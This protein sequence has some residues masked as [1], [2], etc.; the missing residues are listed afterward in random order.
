MKYS[1]GLN[2]DFDLEYAKD[3]FDQRYKHMFEKPDPYHSYHFTAVS[4]EEDVGMGKISEQIGVPLHVQRYFRTK[5]N[6]AG[7]IHIDCRH[8]TRAAR[9][10]AINIPILHCDN[11]TMEWFDHDQFGEFEWLAMAG[12]YRPP[13]D[14]MED[15]NF[16]AKPVEGERMVL[17]M[18]RLV[19]TRTMHRVNNV[20][21]PHD[22]IV[23]SMRTDVSMSY[24]EIYE[25]CKSMNSC[26]DI[27]L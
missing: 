4:I 17:N 7:P 24:E 9:Q 25:K 12:F 20:G 27:T 22:R 14:Q 1:M 5:A 11:S 13:I 21:N 6:T 3:V 18:P 19:E 26:I 2:L 15:K 10:W 8:D 23:L 16:T